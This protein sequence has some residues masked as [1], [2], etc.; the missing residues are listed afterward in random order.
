MES[1][2]IQRTW[3]SE[4]NSGVDVFVFYMP[5][6]GQGKPWEK[7]EVICPLLWAWLKHSSAFE[8]KNRK[9]LNPGLLTMVCGPLFPSL[10]RDPPNKLLFLGQVWRRPPRVYAKVD[11]AAKLENFGVSFIHIHLGF[12]NTFLFKAGGISF[13][14]SLFTKNIVNEITDRNI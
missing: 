8:R 1:D 3:L 12:S 4:P 7:T 2:S 13:L 6:P 9:T 11:F 10:W 14:Q 5:S